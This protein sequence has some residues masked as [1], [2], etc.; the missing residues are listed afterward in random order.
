MVDVVAA[1]VVAADVVSADVVAQAAVAQAAVAA[2][3]ILEEH[4]AMVTMVVVGLDTTP[5]E[6]LLAH[7]GPTTV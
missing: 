1:A 7:L 5:M 4:L 2:L 3:A 6:G